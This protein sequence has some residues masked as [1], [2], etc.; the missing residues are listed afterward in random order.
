MRTS[1]VGAAVAALLAVTSYAGAAHAKAIGGC[2]E[3]SGFALVTVASLGI[4]IEEA[5]GL[6]SLDGNGDG[7][8]CIRPVADG[9][10]MIF[11]DNTVRP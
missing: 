3:Q 11:R 1:L 7:L 6:P 5:E 8:T 4:T 2:P 10:W 9:K